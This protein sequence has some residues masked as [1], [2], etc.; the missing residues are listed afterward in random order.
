[1]KRVNLLVPFIIAF[2]SSCIFFYI[3]NCINNK[4]ILN[5]FINAVISGSIVFGIV[6]PFFNL[7]KIRDL[8]YSQTF[9]NFYFPLVATGFLA[10]IILH[11]LRM[12]IDNIREELFLTLVL[13]LFGG[14]IIYFLQERFYS[15]V[16]TSSLSTFIK[17]SRQKHPVTQKFAAELLMRFLDG[18]DIEKLKEIFINGLQTANNIGELINKLETA[19][20]TSG[21]IYMKDQSDYSLLLTLSLEFNPQIINAMWDTEMISITDAVEKHKYIRYFEELSMAYKKTSVEKYCHRIFIFKDIIEYQAYQLNPN[22][23]TL[24]KWHK[25]WGFNEIYYC[26]K[27]QFNDI[28]RNNISDTVSHLLDDFVIY[29][30][31]EGFK[32]IICRDK[33]TQK[34]YLIHSNITT[35]KETNKFYDLLIKSCKQ[36][37]QTIPLS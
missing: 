12:Y 19:S 18:N 29:S 6:F 21:G 2:I 20:R 28:K 25:D 33:E 11:I 31:S 4:D 23:E 37:N 8:P 5:N 1:M 16:F 26:Y 13:V 14:V 36:D 27:E 3:F 35:L 34:V 10:L 24:K 30:I 7:Q 15:Y 9:L 32:W 17:V 22:W